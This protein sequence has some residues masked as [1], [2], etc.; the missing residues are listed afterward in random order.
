MEASYQAD[1]LST[2]RRQMAQ[3]AI[4]QSSVLRKYRLKF[5]ILGYATNMT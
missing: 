5:E 3:Q 2:L 1:L 4:V